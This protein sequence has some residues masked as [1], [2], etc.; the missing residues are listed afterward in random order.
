[1]L[2][3]QFSTVIYFLHKLHYYIDIYC[4]LKHRQNTIAFITIFADMY[5]VQGV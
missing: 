5:I 2:N 4:V 1:M 3:D